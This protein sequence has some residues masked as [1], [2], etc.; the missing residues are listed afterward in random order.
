MGF[1]VAARLPDTY[2]AE[3]RLLVGPVSGDR[4]TIR[5][6]GQNAR[7]YAELAT[8]RP[9]IE[10]AAASLQLPPDT[11]ESKVHDVT[12]SDVTR[13]VSIRVRDS[14]P[15]RAAQIANAIAEQLRLRGV[16]EGTLVPSGRVSIEERA[17]PPED[18]I[19]PSP[20]LIV[21]VA[22]LAGLLGAFGF[23]VL[24]DSMSMVVRNEEDLARAGPIAFLGSVD[25]LRAGRSHPLV[26]EADPE[27]DAATAYRVL[28]V[29][30]ALSN[31]S[32]QLRSL[33]VLD[34]HGGRSSARLAANL[35]GALAEGD[36]RVVLVDTDEGGE[37]AALFGLY[38]EKKGEDKN[39]L[40]QRARP[41]RV[42]RVS[43]DRF[44]LRRPDLMIVRPRTRV[45][46]FDLDWADELL[47]RLLA[48]ADHV[49][50]TAPPVDRSPSAFLWSRLADATVLVVERD[51]TKR[52]EVP[53]ALESLRIAGANVIGT[54]LCKDRLF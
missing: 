29:K 33:L 27:S 43:L 53:A 11:V 47:E 50:F 10:E 51:H 28:A 36:S 19:G 39:G 14:A 1:L 24:V 35:A 26:L 20:V 13:F 41:L 17:I 5:A 25:G 38:R 16:E 23:A 12:A 45:E 31:G 42:G 9:V 48:D 49:V 15:L 3:A 34:A 37:I 30:I 21:S 18:T 8:T 4:E 22:A 40:V 6:A 46:P 32:Q 52:E 54:V 44:R 2:E 7:L